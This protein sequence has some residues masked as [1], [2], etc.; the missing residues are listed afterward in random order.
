[1][2]SVLE[3]A[4]SM[5]DDWW[6]AFFEIVFCFVL[7]ITTFE[8]IALLC[9]TILISNFY[10]PSPNAYSDTMNH[11]ET[12]VYFRTMTCFLDGSVGKD[13]WEHVRWV[14]IF[15]KPLKGGSLDT[16]WFGHPVENGLNARLAMWVWKKSSITLVLYSI[17]MV[18]D[19]CPGCYPVI[20]LRSIQEN[21]YT[22]NGSWMTWGMMGVA[23]GL[24]IM[25]DE[26]TSDSQTGFF[27]SGRTS[28]E[29]PH[30]TR[31]PRPVHGFVRGNE[32]LF[33]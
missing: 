30:C 18:A 31:L 24:F 20:N 10:S 26:S 15:C 28:P 4:T 32:L 1:V 2:P 8:Y 5:P 19:P 17:T 21:Y 13:D 16:G 22:T 11:S 29:S 12:D 27:Q 25:S 3:L 9:I 7:V 6:I 33:Y 14:Q 23:H